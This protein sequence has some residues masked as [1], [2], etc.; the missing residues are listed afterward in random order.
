[1]SHEAKRQ[2]THILLFLFAF[3]LKYL[4]RFQAILLVL[5]LLLFTILILPKLSVK[6]HFYRPTEDTFSRGAIFYFLTILVLTL[7]F[8]LHIVAASWAVLALGD[9][10]ATLVGRNFKT[11]ELPWN[12]RKSFYG[13]L[14]FVVSATIGSYLL[15]LWMGVSASG[16]ISISL[17]T[18]IVAAIVETLPIK[19]DDNVSVA[20]VSALTLSFLI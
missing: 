17:K 4:D 15:L 2:Y 8:P 12:R 6:K 14:A 16:L 13:S 10:M 11:A 20:V 18:A 1:M 5:G 7:I 9:G 19:I 3:T